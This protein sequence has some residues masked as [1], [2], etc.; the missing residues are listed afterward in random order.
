M[1]ELVGVTETLQ[2]A[3]E[4]VAGTTVTVGQ[5]ATQTEAVPGVVGLK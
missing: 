2:M 4:K 5:D 3:L 1:E